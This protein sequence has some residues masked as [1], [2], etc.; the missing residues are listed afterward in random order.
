MTDAAAFSHRA[1][2]LV[3]LAELRALTALSIRTLIGAYLDEA[4]VEASLEIMG[5]DTRLIEDGTYFAVEDEGRIVGCGGWSRRATLLGGDHSEG[6][7]ARLLDP[8]AE[9]ARIRAMYTHPDFARRGIGAPR[10]VLVRGR[11]GARGLS[12]TRAHGHRRGRAPVPRVWLFG[13]RA[14]RGSHIEGCDRARCP[15]GEAVVSHASALTLLEPR[16]AV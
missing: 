10:A 6:R 12:F 16:R 1:A 13:R 11:R 15:H 3:G 2:T 7:D 4:R 9:P 8:T 14:V 5:V